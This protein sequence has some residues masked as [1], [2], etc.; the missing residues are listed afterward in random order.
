MKNN[1]FINKKEWNTF[2]N[3]EME[4]FE[5]K[6]FQYYRLNGFPYYSD[7]NKWRKKEFNKFISF[8]KKNI[9]DAKEKSFRQVMHGLA[10]ASSYFPHMFSI[11]CNNM[12]TPLDIFYDDILFK[13]CIHKRILMGDNISNNGI[14]KMLKI[15][16]GTQCVSNFRPTVASALYNLFAPNG[17]VLDM[18]A[19]FGGRLLGFYGSSAQKYIGLE[20][21]TK[22]YNS[23]LELNKDCFSFYKDNLEQKEQQIS[24]FPEH[25]FN[26]KIKKEVEIIK[27]GS[28]DYIP[29]SN[30]LDFCFTSPPYFDTEKYSME[31]TQSYT[32]Y[33]DKESWI[34]YFL[35]KTFNNCYIGLKKDK[36]MAINISNVKTFPNLE[37][38]TINIALINGFELI[39]VYYY[40]L[41]SLSH[42]NKY[43]YEPIF[44]FKKN[45][46]NI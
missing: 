38:E 33:P 15:F 30:S 45:S 24:L 20:P 6:V 26:N 27:I 19:G 9:F 34:K 41:S 16:T 17:T 7:D 13:K 44:I 2:S 21:S 3:I 43:K 14:R 12:K 36:Y 40:L 22:T 35:G 29:L 5:Q 18:S 32:K 11:Q 23:L 37:E 31:N 28:E 42:N 4:D 39:D 8:N 1:I 10:L 25:N 46:K